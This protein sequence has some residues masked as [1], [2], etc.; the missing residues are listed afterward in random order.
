MA[1]RGGQGR[2]RRTPPPLSV[3]PSLWAHM[4]APRANPDSGV[5][6]RTKV[7]KADLLKRFEQ[8]IKTLVVFSFGAHLSR[9]IFDSLTEF[10]V[11]IGCS[12]VMFRT[13]KG[14]SCRQL[15]SDCK[16]H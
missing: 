1:L 4:S 7:S 11:I 15:G 2:R 10:S 14:A 5:A 12:A 8:N 13:S 16:V 9:S 3:R 6:T